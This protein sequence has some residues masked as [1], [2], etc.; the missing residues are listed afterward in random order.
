MFS[1]M[2]IF[3]YEIIIFVTEAKGKVPAKYERNNKQFNKG[4]INRCEVL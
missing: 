4:W 2:F 1:T 3:L